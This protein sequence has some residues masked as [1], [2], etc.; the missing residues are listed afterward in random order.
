MKKT[1]LILLFTIISISTLFQSCTGKSNEK[2]TLQKPDSTATVASTDDATTLTFNNLQAAF[3]GET[4]ARAKYEAYSKKANEEGYF[5]IAML[6]HAASMAENIHA[7]NHKAVLEEAGQ[8]VPVIS[9]EFTV[10]STKDNLADAIKGESYESETMY[11][12]F[13][14]N[15]KATNNELAGISFNY[16]YKTE[17]KHL[18]MYQDAQTALENNNAKSLPKVYYVCPTCGNTY[19]T[20]KPKRCGISMT[21]SEKFIEITTL[22]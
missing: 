21:N 16:A 8:T 19:Q 9:P 20:I 7:N 2:D 14:V 12:E 1:V 6:F 4:T 13:M 18:K 10:N 3:K 15:A 5:E 17:L 11:P 22:N